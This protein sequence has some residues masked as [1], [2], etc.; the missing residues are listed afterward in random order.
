MKKNIISAIQDIPLGESGYEND[1]D[2]LG[3]GPY[4]EALVQFVTQC[5]TPMTVAIQ[6][7]WGTGKT[8][9]MRLIEKKISNQVHTIWFNTWQFS[10]FSMGEALP[11]SFLTAIAERMNTQNSESNISNK[12]KSVAKK[13]GPMFFKSVLRVGANAATGG[14]AGEFLNGMASDEKQ[15]DTTDVFDVSA[16][17]KLKTDFA[18][19]CSEKCLEQKKSRVVI[20]VDDLDRIQPIRAVE[21]LETLKMFLDVPNCV[22]VLALD[23][24]VVKRGLGE[25]FGVSEKDLDGRSFFDKIIQLPFTMPTASYK[26]EQYVE[27]LLTQVGFETHMNRIDMYRELLVSSIGA[28][29]RSIKRLINV[30]RL[31]NIVFEKQTEALN[32][33]DGVNLIPSVKND[34][35]RELLLFAFVCLQTGYEKLYEFLK[36]NFH[37]DTIDKLR[38]EQ[39]YEEGTE[40]HSVVSKLP[41]FPG[42]KELIINFMNCFYDSV[43]LD[44]DQKISE[45][46]LAAM[47]YILSNLSITSVE[48]QSLPIHAGS[49]VKDD[50]I[51][52]I[53]QR[54]KQGFLKQIN[55]INKSPLQHAIR[56][57]GGRY[58]QFKFDDYYE[59]NIIFNPETRGKGKHDRE[60][61]LIIGIWY[62]TDHLG[63]NSKE[64]K[65]ACEDLTNTLEANAPDDWDVE[66]SCSKEFYFG[67]SITEP[68]VI[69]HKNLVDHI[70]TKLFHGF[71]IIKKAIGDVD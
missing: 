44:G 37:P 23:Y 38:K 52:Q 68:G 35:H 54:S 48:S 7:D 1:N 51:T 40:L 67:M 16:F 8:S 61:E 17:E 30:V 45:D 69:P 60:H 50:L 58:M 66:F 20:F 56:D 65:K 24:A 57:E 41:G 28:N 3:V 14:L 29:P 21:L 22:F 34:E 9:M 15:P 6:G 39:S 62:Y 31:M 63:K 42:N 11:L 19:A 36:N 47:Q 71:N 5:G 25:K 4:V 43:D 26:L 32:E 12:V 55:G 70:S 33:L 46:E 13:Y 49:S 53:C 64:R 59:A 2:A 27:A 10:Q 18:H